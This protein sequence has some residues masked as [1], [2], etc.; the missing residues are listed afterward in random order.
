[1]TTGDPQAI[2]GQLAGRVEGWPAEASRLR[3][4]VV[5]MA[6]PMYQGVDAQSFRVEAGGRTAWARIPQADAALFAEPATL[7]AAARMA[8]ACGAGPA[9]LAADEATGAMLLADLSASHRAG[10]LDR[11]IDPGIREAALVARK[12]IHAGPALPRSR[13]VLAHVPDLAAQAA[14]AGVALPQDWAWMADSIAAAGAAIAASGIDTVP[15]HGDGNASNLMIDRA[16]G[17]LLVDFDMAANMD[18]YEDLGSFLVEAHAF[19]PGAAET[20]E[21]F[22]GRFDSRLFNRARLYG[23]A[24]DVRWGLIGAILAAT[25]PRTDLEFLKYA[26]WRFLRARFAMRDPRFE[27]RIR[28]V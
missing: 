22:H 10:T 14:R 20:F 21:M 28:R 7:V 4:G 25:S 1:M 19:D 17:V 2:A 5:P 24:D 16:G 11:L 27:E 15:A 26:D 6:S 23:V 13:S 18:P 3:P 8:A 9:V 12:A